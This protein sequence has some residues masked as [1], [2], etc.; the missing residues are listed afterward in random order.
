MKNQ[1]FQCWKCFTLIAESINFLLNWTEHVKSIF[2]TLANHLINSKMGPLFHSFCK[3]SGIQIIYL[4]LPQE[5][6]YLGVYLHWRHIFVLLCSVGRAILWPRW[7][8]PRP[9]VQM[10]CSN[11]SCG[12]VNLCL[13]S[14]IVF[15]EPI[16]FSHS[17]WSTTSLWL[18]VQVNE[19]K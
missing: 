2:M 7:V 11:S 16:F 8:R 19:D 17:G 13:V 18:S 15:V 10:E 12:K 3:N 1:F 6:E 4:R 14:Y 5:F 9:R